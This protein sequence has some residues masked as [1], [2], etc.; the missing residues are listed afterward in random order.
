DQGVPFNANIPTEEVYTSPVKSGTHGVVTSTKPLSYQGNLIENFTLRFEE[1]RGGDFQAERG[2][3]TLKNLLE[4]DEGAR[5]LGEIALVPHD[6][7]ISDT[8][9]IF[10]NTVFDA[11]ASRHLALGKAF[12]FCVEGSSSMKEEELAE[13]GLNDS[14]PHVDFRIG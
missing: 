9:L 14:I 13:I 11:N 7:P 5:Y 6:S 2:Y 3:D 1:G 8:T 4:S 12:S 10:V